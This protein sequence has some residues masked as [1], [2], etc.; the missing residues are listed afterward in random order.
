MAGSC[1]GAT[2][3]PAVDTRSDPCERPLAFASGIL[4]R[5]AGPRAAA[6]LRARPGPERRATPRPTRT[7]R[8]PRHRRRRT[9]PSPGPARGSAIRCGCTPRGCRSRPRRHARS[10]TNGLSAE[11]VTCSWIAPQR[12]SSTDDTSIHV[13][14][15]SSGNQHLGGVR[16]ELGDLL[17]RRVRGRRP[18]RALA[19]LLHV[20]RERVPH[21]GG[22][23]L[24]VELRRRPRREAA[25]ALGRA[26]AAVLGR[27]LLRVARRVAAA[28]TRADRDQVRPDVVGMAVPAERVVGRHDVGGTSGRGTRAGRW[29]RPC[30]PAR[31]SASRFPARP[32]MSESL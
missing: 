4:G 15:A 10:R 16:L 13:V 6:A 1:G 25:L 23:R 8:P 21:G 29:P 7:V 11:I 20:G 32:I 31:S 17:G 30:P 27:E 9:G 28:R 24:L 22:D 14:I 26:G 5:V 2:L 18:E 19:D 3:G 12:W